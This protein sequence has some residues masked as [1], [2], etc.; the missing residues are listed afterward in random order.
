[1]TQ[2]LN[3]RYSPWR[4]LGWGTIAAL[5]AL[6]AILRF[7]WTASDFIIMGLL[8]GSVG[9]GIEYLVRLSGNAFV[10]LGAILAVLT[11]FMTIWS[12]LAVGMIGSEDNNYNLLF[13]GLLALVLTGSIRVRMHPAAMVK[14]MLAAA[15][16]QGALALGG[17][18]VDQRG[19]LFSGIFVI[20]WLLSA[21]L[22][23]A[24]STR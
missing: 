16:G 19:A 15:A 10:R 2:T 12:N 9:L 4:L 8:L 18:A 6:P 24:G 17:L 21:A 7:P 1:M 23:R 20:S 14:V 3:R 11:S 13:I 5:L 22:F